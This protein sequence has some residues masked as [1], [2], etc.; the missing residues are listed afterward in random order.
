MSNGE[1]L[2][3]GTTN[4][5]DGDVKNPKGKSDGWFIV[6]DDNGK[7]LQQKN[8]GSKDYEVLNNAIHINGRKYIGIGYSR[9][10]NF[11]NDIWIEE[12]KN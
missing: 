4:S 2:V 5:N 10:Q 12:F 8:I 6:I 3:V 9:D 11:N 7:L 1:Y